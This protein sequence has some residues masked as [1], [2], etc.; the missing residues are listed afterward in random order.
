MIVV[1]ASV[2]VQWFY[3]EPLSTR[4]HVLLESTRSDGE[5]LAA[6]GLLL[7]EFSNRVR[8]AVR[9]GE[10]VD[11]AER[12]VDQFCQLPIAILPR[13]PD[14]L[15]MVTRRALA[16]ANRFDLQATYD[17]H[18]LA[19]AE[20]LDCD[21]WTADRRLLNTLGDRLPFVRDLA[22]FPA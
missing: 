3:T 1:D 4:A 16:I 18:Y 19:L 10:S 9:R 20:L 2:A 5:V 21:F 8:Q 7:T 14:E 17:A 15:R 22:T 12:V 11:V 6:P 13:L